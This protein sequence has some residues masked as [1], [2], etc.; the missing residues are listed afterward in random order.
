[1]NRNTK[2]IIKKI[3]NILLNWKK[4]D[5]ARKKILLDNKK[6]FQVQACPWSWKTTLLVAKLM[7]LAQTI[8]FSTESICI[9][10]HTNVAVD[11][12]KRKIKKHNKPWYEDFINKVYKLFDYPNYVWTIQSF[13]DKYL[14]IPWYEK[15]F[16][17]KPN[18]IWDEFITKFNWINYNI[19][20]DKLE[21]TD[22]KLNKLLTN[23]KIEYFKKQIQIQNF[24]KLSYREIDYFSLKH[25]GESENIKNLLQK[26]FNYVFL[27]EIQDTHSLHIEILNKLYNWSTNNI[28]QWF[29]DYNQEI[30]DDWNDWWKFTI[31]WKE[32][33]KQ[34]NNSLRLSSVIA[35]NVKNVC[36]KPQPLKW[37]DRRNIPIYFIIFDKPEE[38]IPKYLK[39]INDHKD[40][41]KL[42]EKDDFKL[43]EKEDLIFKAVWWVQKEKE[44]W[45]LSIWSYWNKYNNWKIIKSKANFFAYFQKV[46]EKDFKNK[47]YSIYKDNFIS[48]IL[49]IFNQN[50]D[51][52]ILYKYIDKNWIEK[53]KHFSKTTFIDYLKKND[54]YNEFQK[55]IFQFSNNI[56]NWTL[57]WDE[58]K[59]YI[60]SLE[61]SWKKVKND[62]F[63]KNNVYWTPEDILN[64]S[65][66]NKFSENSIKIWEI[67]THIQFATIAKVKW[68]THTWTL[69]LDTDFYE[70]NTSKILDFWNSDIDKNTEWPHNKKWLKNHYVAITRA[71]HLLCIAVHK[72][73][74]NISL[75][76]NVCDEKNI[77]CLW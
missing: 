46:D 51:N 60:L 48:W 6:S 19:I 71:T 70:Q 37:I 27:D 53:E 32:N 73:R 66:D 5:K 69:V 52:Q 30:F 20:L 4:F 3:E 36:V 64:I 40:D 43:I 13:L 31:F 74:S 17:K 39:I 41:F 8:D 21:T 55:S 11:E 16:K 45:K 68:E 76:K 58:V 1:M 54:L 12:I 65:K 23:S 77:K 44:N 26:R 61:I 42:I 7:F 9:L 47:W 18:F 24:W 59:N 75:I 33:P 49:H 10:T 62:D 22:N 29:W 67:E 72:D 34:I 56:Q 38:V 25:L 35:E 63:L 15:K 14:W 2:E 28:I 50:K 57:K